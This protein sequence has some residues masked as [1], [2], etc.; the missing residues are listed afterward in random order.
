M[1]ESVSATDCEALNQLQ[2]LRFRR[3]DAS[4]AERS[5][6]GRVVLGAGGRQL[7]LQVA[8]HRLG[9]RTDLLDG[10]TQLRVVDV[11]QATPIGDVDVAQEVD[12]RGRCDRRRVRFDDHACLLRSEDESIMRRHG[13]RVEGFPLFSPWHGQTGRHMQSRKASLSTGTSRLRVEGCS[14]TALLSLAHQTRTP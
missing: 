5:T 2:A 6:A 11:Q 3:A 8:H 14:A 12:A 13:C 9:A 10:S 7:A 1:V 4:V